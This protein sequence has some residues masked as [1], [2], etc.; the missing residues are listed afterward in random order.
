LQ[1]LP[2]IPQVLGAL[3][4]IS[5]HRGAQ[6]YTLLLLAE[7]LLSIAYIAMLN[8]AFWNVSTWRAVLVTSFVSFVS[9]LTA[10]LATMLLLAVLAG[11]VTALGY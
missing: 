8:R 1:L 2:G 5:I 11:A 6:L 4:I 3:R 9:L 10:V 7:L